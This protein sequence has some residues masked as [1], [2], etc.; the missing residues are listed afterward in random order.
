M[1]IHKLRNG[2]CA[3]E[4]SVWKQDAAS[5]QCSS[6]DNDYHCVPNDNNILVELC[7]QQIWVDP[8]NCPEYNTGANTLDTVPCNVSTGSC[9]DVLFLS[10]EVYKYPACLN[11]TIIGDEKISREDILKVPLPWIFVGVGILVFILLLIVSCVVHQ[12]RRKRQPKKEEEEMLLID[13]FNLKKPFYKTSAFYEGVEFIKSDGKILCLEGKWGSGKRSTAKQVYVAVTNSSPIM[14]SHPLTFDV[15]E[16]HEPIIADMTLFIEVSESEKENLAEKMQM[17]FENMPSS[18]TYTKAFI[19]FLIDEDQENIGKFVRSLGKKTK[20]ID[21][22]EELT[23][24][25]RTQILYS[26]FET[27]CRHKKFSEVENLAVP[28]GNSHFLG[29]S[30]ICALFCRCTNFQRFGPVLFRNA[31]LRYLKSNLQDMHN[32]DKEK[33]LILV[34]MSLNK[35]VISVDNQTDMLHE[36]LESCNCDSSKK[37]ISSSAEQN[38]ITE[39]EATEKTS[40]NRQG[41]SSEKKLKKKYTSKEYITSIIPEEFVNKEADPSVYRLQHDVIKRMTLIVYG[42]HHFDKLLEL[43]KP[44]ELKTWVKEKGMMPDV[45]LGDIEPV[46]KISGVKWKQYQEIIN[47]GKNSI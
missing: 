12:R 22:S 20:F 47:I 36:I 38:N 7:I 17:L 37:E 40:Q 24:G 2:P 18:N 34:Y 21:L 10:K 42:T 13:N 9:P 27:F 33:F 28:I 25:D 8:N 45:G 14:I 3:Y 30:E 43:S 41:I 39:T 29:Y 5:F 44:E 31:P 35:M 11:K 26:Q 6:P 4:E 19:I 32:S 23:N 16:H 15:K 1:V 46:L